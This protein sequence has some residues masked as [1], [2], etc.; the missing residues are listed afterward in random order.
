M[1]VHAHG[2]GLRLA[3]VLVGLALLPGVGLAQTPG[4]AGSFG[5]LPRSV[6]AGQIVIVTD[7]A[8]RDTRGKVVE[9]SDSSLV[10]LTRDQN[11]QWTTRETF[12]PSA[13]REVKRTG[14]IWDGALI[15]FGVGLAPVLVVM[16]GNR[17]HGC[18]VCGELALMT[19]GIGAGIGLGID[20]AF[21]PK[22]VY[23]S[24]GSRRAGVTISPVI[25]RDRKGAVLALRF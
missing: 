20:A 13:V 25:G 6:K 7:G 5:D 3:S 22:R 24:P 14:P 11:R 18:F 10:I 17:E 4:A 12:A 2:W 23:R 1:T 21:G 8:G 15:G 16:V 9:A 19:G